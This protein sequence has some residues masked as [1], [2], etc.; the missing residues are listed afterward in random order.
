MMVDVCELFMCKFHAVYGYTHSDELVIIIPSCPIKK[1]VFQQHLYNGR[2]QKLC[3]IASS[4]VTCRFAFLLFGFFHSKG[5]DLHHKNFNFDLF[6]TFDCRLGRYSS[7]SEGLLLGAEQAVRSC[8][9]STLEWLK[10]NNLLPLRDLHAYG[11]FLMKVEKQFIGTNPVTNE[12]VT[13]TRRVIEKTSG[14]VIQFLI[15]NNFF[16]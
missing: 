7:R 14:N 3:S 15:K 9:K 1:N 8:T 13:Y 4:F 10:A 6:P 11:T 12:S 5:V 2:V 16:L